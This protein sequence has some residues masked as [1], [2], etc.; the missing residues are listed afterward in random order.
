MEPIV[1]TVTVEPIVTTVTAEPIVSKF[2]EKV[3]KYYIR[4]PKE[5]WAANLHKL[6]SRRIK[7]DIV[8]PFMF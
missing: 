7:E 4:N 8:E 6:Q 3:K 2:T 1:T 5:L